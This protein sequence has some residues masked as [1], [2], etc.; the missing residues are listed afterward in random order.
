MGYGAHIGIGACLIQNVSVGR[1]AIVGAGAA[2]IGDVPTKSV[3]CGVPA[4]PKSSP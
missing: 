2:V 4:R 3:V 1:R